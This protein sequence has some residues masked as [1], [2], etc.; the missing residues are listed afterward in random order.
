MFDFLAQPR[1]KDVYR[2]VEIIPVAIVH[3]AQQ[4]LAAQH[5]ACTRYERVE[6]T[7]LAAGE[8]N[9]PPVI[10]DQS[11]RSEVKLPTGEARDFLTGALQR[12]LANPTFQATQN[13]ADSREQLAPIKRLNQ[14]VV[15]ANF[16]SDDSVRDFAFAG[17]NDDAAG[18]A[19]PQMARE[20][21]AVFAWQHDVEDDKV[22]GLARND[23][24]E[25]LAFA[26]NAHAIPFLDQIFA[27]RFAKEVVVFDDE[28]M[29]SRAHAGEYAKSVAK[30]ALTKRS[31]CAAVTIET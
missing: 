21:E 18:I 7:V 12:N 11:S 24:P 28:D 20:R 25:L 5:A 16:K 1:D 22:D 27:Q 2:A 4:V 9:D 3:T 15:G 23:A 31:L 17:D 13:A 30:K 29:L 10:V 14:I 6:Q 19:I 8:I 26:G